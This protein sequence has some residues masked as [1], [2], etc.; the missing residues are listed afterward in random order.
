V[1]SKT[2]NEAL[3]TCL[4]DNHKV[5][6]Y[7]AKVIHE[8]IMAD[9]VMSAEERDLLAKALHNNQFDDKAYALLSGLLL[10]NQ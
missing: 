1:A 7:E 8:L 5:S 9:G 3:T 4:K 10:R 2:L 6:L